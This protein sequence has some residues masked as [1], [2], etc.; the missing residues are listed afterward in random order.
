[1]DR[2]DIHNERNKVRTSVTHRT[3]L[4][5]ALPS[6]T[7]R[8]GPERWSDLPRVTQVAVKIPDVVSGL[9]P[10]GL[11]KACVPS[12]V[13]CCFPLRPM[14]FLWRATHRESVTCH[15]ILQTSYLQQSQ[16]PHGV[17][18]RA[19][20]APSS[21]SPF[22]LEFVQHKAPGWTESRLSEL[23]REVPMSQRQ[24]GPSPGCKD[25]VSDLGRVG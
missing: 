5:E 24:G 20:V 23:P 17:L 8:L 15:R 9:G 13:P 7:R 18:R 12:S 21:Q 19:S 4:W 16:S 14:P 10:S 1:M 25:A 11:S 2:L 3:G 22:S 6:G